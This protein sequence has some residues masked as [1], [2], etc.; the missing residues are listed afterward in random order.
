MTVE[1][2]DA[3]GAVHCV[4]FQNGK[5]QLATRAFSAGA[6]EAVPSRVARVHRSE[7]PAAKD[8]RY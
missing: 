1:S 7:S 5:G 6:L 8:D 4:W 3:Q 2:V